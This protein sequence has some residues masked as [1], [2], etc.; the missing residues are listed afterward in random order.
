LRRGRCEG[1]HLELAGNERAELRSTPP[2][3]VV[4]HEECR[5]ILV[6]TEE[7]GL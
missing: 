2:D 6:R 7:S 5:R 4:R 1:C 3:E